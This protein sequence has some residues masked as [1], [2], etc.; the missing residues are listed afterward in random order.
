MHVWKI[1][2]YVFGND[3]T[4]RGPCIYLL[5]GAKSLAVSDL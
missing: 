1:Q 3:D 2:N 5:K 4:Q